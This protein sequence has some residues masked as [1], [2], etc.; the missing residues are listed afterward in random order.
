MLYQLVIKNRTIKKK[1]GIVNFTDLLFYTSVKFTFN[2]G[3]D[4]NCED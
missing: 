1:R 4:A 3:D 2:W